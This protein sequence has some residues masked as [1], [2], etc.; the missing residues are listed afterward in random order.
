MRVDQIMTRRI[1]TVGMDDS[2]REVAALF[3]A[4]RFHHLLVVDAGRLVGI[5][6]DRDLLRHISPFVG[7][8]SE[9]EQDT[10]TLRKHVHQIMSRNLLTVPESASLKQAADA[11]L[12]RR[13]SC[14]PVIDERGVA[15]GLVTIHDLLRALAQSVAASP[16][17]ARLTV[18]P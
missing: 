13:V 4:H 17:S 16:G 15:V 1:V 2:L 3:D 14:L 10:A 8:L 11:M 12:S 6:S 5:V 7:K 18:Q 9:R